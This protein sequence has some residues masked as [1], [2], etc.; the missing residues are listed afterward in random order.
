MFQEPMP[1]ERLF[2]RPGLEPPYHWKGRRHIAT[3]EAEEHALQF[4]PA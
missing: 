3:Y 1:S 4:W 2:N